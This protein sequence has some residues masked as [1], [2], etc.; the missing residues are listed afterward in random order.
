MTDIR[1]IGFLLVG[2][3]ILYLLG[4][5]IWGVIWYRFLSRIMTTLLLSAVAIVGIA[6]IA[7]PKSTFARLGHFANFAKGVMF[8][9]PQ[10]QVE[11]ALLGRGTGFTPTGLLDPLT[12]AKA[13]VAHDAPINQPS[14]QSPASYAPQ[15]SQPETR[16]AHKKI[17]T[18]LA[19]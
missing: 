1:F 4:R 6:L 2:A 18:T 9:S 17:V 10:A 5:W 7:A 12:I 13:L 8:K 15:D 11:T 3:A 14:S 19:E 16:H